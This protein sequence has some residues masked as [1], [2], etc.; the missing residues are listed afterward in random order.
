MGL[1]YAHLWKQYDASHS[2][3][4]ENLIRLKQNILQSYKLVGTLFFFV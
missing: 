3:H 4:C 1:V 2:L